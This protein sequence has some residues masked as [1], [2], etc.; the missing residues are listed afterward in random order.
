MHALRR[1]GIIIGVA[2]AALLGGIAVVFGQAAG[3]FLTATPV[4]GLA[5]AVDTCDLQSYS[6][7]TINQMTM[8]T[9]G[10]LCTSDG[11][12]GTAVT[13]VA[14]SVPATSIFGV[15]G[16]PITTAGTI[17]LTMTGTSGGI[18]YFSSA[19]VL[20][21]SAVLTNHRIVLGGGAAAS[22]KLVGSLGTATTVLHGAAAGDPTFG[23]VALATDVSGILPIAN[24]Q[25]GDGTPSG[26]TSCGTGSPA[27][28]AGA[29]DLRG[30]VDTGG[31]AVL[32]CTIAF[33][34]T[35]STA[36]ICVATNQG[37]TPIA[38]SV[39]AISTSAATFTFA[40]ALGSGKFNYHCIP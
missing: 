17:G 26:P 21:S 16:S 22:P 18:P 6:A 39:S 20:S 28:E 2:L 3:T 13:S 27:L 8:T 35:Y 23:A 4:M 9:G 34:G 38:I 36:P 5:L 31:G 29:T 30:V 14:L 12:S 1:P 32:A 15:T 37:A 24:L 11:T 33:G 7:G 25:G 19:S 10:E 40:A